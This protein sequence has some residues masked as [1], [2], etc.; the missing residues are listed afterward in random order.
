LIAE[1]ANSKL[2]RVLGAITDGNAE[3]LKE[4]VADANKAE[5]H[6]L[7]Y[8]RRARVMLEYT[9]LLLENGGHARL[10]LYKKGGEGCRA[11]W[12]F[13]VAVASAPMVS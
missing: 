13:C 6:L 12:V 8:D 11:L 7:G 1:Q 10:D 9:T 4:L 3:P 2:R 5:K